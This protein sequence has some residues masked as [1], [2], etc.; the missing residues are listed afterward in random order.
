MSAACRWAFSL[1]WLLLLAA[2]KGYWAPALILPLYYIADASITLARRVT[3]RAAFWEAHREHFYQRALARDGDHG[4]VARLVFWGDAVLVLLALA[5]IA[6][7]LA[8]LAAAVIAVAVMLALLQR[9]SH[10]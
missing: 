1:G 2:A 4:A 9:R 8:A 6:Q 10:G 5:A 3:R 7:P